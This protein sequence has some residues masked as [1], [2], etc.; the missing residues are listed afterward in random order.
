MKEIGFLCIV[1]V[2]INYIPC[3]LYDIFIPHDIKTSEIKCYRLPQQNSIM[4]VA[5]GLEV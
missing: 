1:D 4:Q 3:F 2:A 5:N